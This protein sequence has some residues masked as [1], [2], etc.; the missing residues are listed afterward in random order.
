MTT[1]W[2]E[3]GPGSVREAVRGL[4]EDI[5]FVPDFG[6]VRTD[7]YR[8]GYSAARND[9]VPMVD[10]RLGELMDVYI[11]LDIAQALFTDVGLGEFLTKRIPVW[12]NRTPI[13]RMASGEAAAVIE[14]L[15]AEYEGQV[16]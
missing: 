9:V 2:D 16:G 7:D 11:A 3:S 1:T 14:L 13:E 12:G 6:P 5:K 4:L 10:A 15:A 8:E